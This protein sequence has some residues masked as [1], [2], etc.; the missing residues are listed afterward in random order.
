[1][2]CDFFSIRIR[3]DDLHRVSL[4]YGLTNRS[5]VKLKDPRLIICP[6]RPHVV[7][8]TMD[9]LQI[10]AECSQE[11]LAIAIRDHGVTVIEHDYDSVLSTTSAKRV[12]AS[13]LVVV[14]QSVGLST[15]FIYGYG[16]KDDSH[17]TASEKIPQITRLCL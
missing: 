2:D 8:V 11:A 9:P 14:L 17:F 13:K 4:F 10:L 1:M 6:E 16:I 3:I 7:A 15:S 5:I 12:S